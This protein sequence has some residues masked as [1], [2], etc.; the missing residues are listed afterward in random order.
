MSRRHGKLLSL[1]GW[2][3][4]R[5]RILVVDDCSEL[6]HAWARVITRWGHE[7]TVA[8]DGPTALRAATVAAFDAALLDIDLPGMDGFEI[9][10]AL[11]RL[12]GYQAIFLIA[13]TGR[14]DEE[15]RR[16]AAA[17]GIQHYLTKPIPARELMVLLQPDA[18]VVAG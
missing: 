14:W 16:R 11:R 4:K 8:T 10:R 13:V 17:V 18:A 7:V 9:A 1:G 5:L 6:A 15:D 2:S 12:P 3:M